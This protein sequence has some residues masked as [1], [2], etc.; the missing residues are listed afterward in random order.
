MLKITPS[1]PK[2]EVELRNWEGSVPKGLF[3]TFP[4]L[5]GKSLS[6]KVWKVWKRV[7]IV[8]IFHSF[9]RF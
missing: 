6:W 4:G 9:R 8:T 5:F 3:G 7:K 2:T 1:E